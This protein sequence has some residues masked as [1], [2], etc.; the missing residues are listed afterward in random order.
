MW[1]G[2]FLWA[3]SATPIVGNCTG[4]WGPF[5]SGPAG[6]GLTLGPGSQRPWDLVTGQ[7][8][9]FSAVIADLGQVPLHAYSLIRHRLAFHGSDAA[10]PG[11]MGTMVYHQRAG[12][13]PKRDR[14]VSTAP[15]PDSPEL[16]TIWRLYGSERHIV[17][18]ATQYV[19]GTYPEKRQPLLGDVLA[20]FRTSVEWR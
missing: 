1:T 6:I 5:P 16:R 19:H 14:I 17:A 7:I 2:V 20:L 18:P 15:A 8:I 12:G 9:E 3:L 11:M 13:S 4:N 10:L